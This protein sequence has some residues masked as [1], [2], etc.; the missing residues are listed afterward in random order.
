MNPECTEIFCP[1]IRDNY[2]LK[3]SKRKEFLNLYDF[4]RWYD[5][6]NQALRNLDVEYFKIREKYFK[7]RSREKLINHYKFN[8]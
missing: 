1:I 8:L 7:K 4:A 6:I 3:R 2:Y 5:F